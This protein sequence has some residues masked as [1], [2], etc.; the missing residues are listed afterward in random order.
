MVSLSDS[1]YQG[2]VKAIKNK[3]PYV[4][5]PTHVKK[6]IPQDIYTKM[7]IFNYKDLKSLV[8]HPESRKE[9][10]RVAIIFFLSNNKAE[11]SISLRTKSLILVNNRIFVP[12][13]ARPELIRRLHISHCGYQ[14][15]ISMYRQ[16]Y[17]W[18][19]AANQI[20]STVARCKVC[21]DHRKA[22]PKAP[23]VSSYPL[24]PEP[25]SSVGCDIFYGPNGTYFLCIVCRLSGFPFCVKIKDMTANS[26]IKAL[27]PLCHIFGYMKRLRT[28]SAKC[29]LGKD[30]QLWLEKHAIHHE[31]SSS[32]HQQSDG[33]SEQCVAICKTLLSKLNWDFDEFSK[34]LGYYRTMPRA[35]NQPSASSIFLARELRF[36]LPKLPGSYA[37]NVPKAIDA[38]NERL[39]Y[40]SSTQ[41]RFPGSPLRD[42]QIGELC[43]IYSFGKSPCWTLRGTVIYRERQNENGAL[44]YVLQLQNDK[45]L[46][47]R[48]SST[49]DTIVK[50]ARIHLIPISSPEI[51][52]DFFAVE[53]FGALQLCTE[54]QSPIYEE[55]ENHIRQIQM[56]KGNFD[57]A[58]RMANQLNVYKK[59]K[60]TISTLN[61]LQG[62]IENQE[63]LESFQTENQAFINEFGQM[64]MED[65]DKKEP[66]APPTSGKT[67]AA[68]ELQ[69]P[70]TPMPPVAYDYPP[71]PFPMIKTG[72][73]AAFSD[74]TDGDE[75]YLR[76]I[77]YLKQEI[78][79]DPQTSYWYGTPVGPMNHLSQMGPGPR[80]YARAVTATGGEAGVPTPATPGGMPGVA[81]KPG[82]EQTSGATGVE[83]GESILELTVNKLSSK[84]E[85]QKRLSFSEVVEKFFY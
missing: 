63:K 50:R 44:R 28:D 61:N 7:S 30:F 13:K 2:I 4:K 24:Y 70:E 53:K 66:T 64:S 49:L 55:L 46:Y 38:C 41:E 5:L 85:D 42:I 59:C 35:N 83:K 72:G 71:P 82:E 29:F 9:G 80:T 56:K 51:N 76:A 17:W 10:M 12:E 57:L 73:V 65:S 78:R 31:T 40:I 68:L 15:M 26:I 34:Q 45:G 33:F 74:F 3:K 48:H 37:L 47:K 84:E 23:L 20:S 81:S 60:T 32:Y 6:E 16:F 62:L 67:P 14:K 43:A 54:N 1:F 39:K 25:W 8:N 21:T 69:R 79:A 11:K 27:E 58:K 18:K 52:D 36:N 75:H 77:E 19:N 22:L